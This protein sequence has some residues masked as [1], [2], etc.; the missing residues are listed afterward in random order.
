MLCAIEI[1]FGKPLFFIS[2]DSHLLTHLADTKPSWQ[3]QSQHVYK[4][5][6]FPDNLQT[7]ASW[8]QHGV[9]VNIV[10]QFGWIQTPL[11]TEPLDK[12][13]S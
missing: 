1:H 4:N 7:S 11:G 3:A 8:S 5:V 13:S 2:F 10:C 9:M 12:L 6:F